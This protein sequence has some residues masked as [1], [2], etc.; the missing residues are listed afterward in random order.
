M[1]QRTAAVE[2]LERNL[3]Y[4]FRDK[5]RLDLA[6]THASVGGANR[7]KDNERYEFLGD[8]VLGLLVAE[9]LMELYPDLPEGKL[10]PRF[11]GLVDK[12]ACAEASRAMGIGPAL[13]LSPGETKT[14]G[15]EK[16]TVLADA[17]EAVMA[18]VYLDGGLE[19]ARAVFRR[20]WDDQIEHLAKPAARDPKSALQAWAQG[21][22]KPVPAYEVV[23]RSG[24]DHAPSFIVQVVVDGLEPA[25]AGGPSRQAA[26]KAAAAELLNREGLT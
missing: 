21:K 26:E 5:K 10:T 23:K 4:A 8:R 7:V 3:G 24:P 11:H 6:L 9:R 12:S 19:A 18:A 16:D 1:N 15:R 25:K 2:E 20:F 13:R 22:A 17:C 14:G